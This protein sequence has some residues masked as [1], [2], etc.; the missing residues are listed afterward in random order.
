MCSPVSMVLFMQVI[1]TRSPFR[2]PFLLATSAADGCPSPAALADEESERQKNNS[3]RRK[4]DNISNTAKDPLVAI[5]LGHRKGQVA[6]L[7]EAFYL[8]LG[9]WGL[10]PARAGRSPV[11][12]VSKLRRVRQ[13]GLRLK[14]QAW[15]I[16]REHME[17]SSGLLVLVARKRWWNKG[18]HTSVVVSFE[19]R[20]MG[21]L[22]DKHTADTG[23]R[24]ENDPRPPP[25]MLTL[26]QMLLNTRRRH[27]QVRSCVSSY[28]EKQ[29]G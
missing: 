27:I 29:N 3:A 15:H 23:V 8:L 2:Y 9:S 20:W 4:T 22:Y 18:H 17:Q 26:E 25:C 11:L 7:V 1:G 14:P 16:G 28:P 6:T 13:P 19:S 12:K 24:G 10:S 5:Y 21:F